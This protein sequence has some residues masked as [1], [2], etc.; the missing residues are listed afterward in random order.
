MLAQLVGFAVLALTLV[1]PLQL[2]FGA[3]VP[4]YLL[5]FD[6]CG[7]SEDEKAHD[8]RTECSDGGLCNRETGQCECG[9]LFHGAACEYMICPGGTDDACHAHGR[10]GG[11]AEWSIEV[12]DSPASTLGPN[13]AYQSSCCSRVRRLHVGVCASSYPHPTRLLRQVPG[14]IFL[15]TVVTLQ[16]T[17]DGNNWP[18]CRRLLRR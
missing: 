4:P 2:G 12:I 5:R 15:T 17:K 13:G 3:N 1:R 10:L 18:P 7:C 14:T 8:V 9:G 6:P 16:W 11:A